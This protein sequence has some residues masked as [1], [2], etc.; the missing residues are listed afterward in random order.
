MSIHESEEKHESPVNS[1]KVLG[2]SWNAKSDTL[3]QEHSDL[4]KYAETLPPTKRSVFK[5]SAKI[6]D[7]IGLIAPLTIHTK[8]W[9]QVLCLSDQI[10]IVN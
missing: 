9:F 3:H 7:P 8:V 4:V 5:Q 6:F 1:V 2:V 10:G